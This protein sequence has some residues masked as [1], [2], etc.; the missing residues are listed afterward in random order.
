MKC[1]ECNTAGHS[2]RNCRARNDGNRPSE[3]DD[4]GLQ[5]GS[6][7]AKDNPKDPMDPQETSSMPNAKVDA[8]S[9]KE[10]ID[11]SNSELNNS[12]EAPK[13]PYGSHQWLLQVMHQG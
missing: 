5:A 10:E 2:K 7:I 8:S 13:P 6:N 3:G 4:S 11:L 1:T 12:E 9:T